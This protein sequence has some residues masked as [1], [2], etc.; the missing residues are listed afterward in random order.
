MV[1]LLDRDGKVFIAA[2]QVLSNI[3]PSINVQMR[4]P[5]GNPLKQFYD[6]F[7]VLLGLPDDC[8]V[9]P[10]HGR[11]FMGLHERVIQLRDHHDERLDFILA[12]CLSR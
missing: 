12:S 6:S 11:P 7:C 3:T 8:A 2:D 10:S 1:C 5:W 9:L 4:E